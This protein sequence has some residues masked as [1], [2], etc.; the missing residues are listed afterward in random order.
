MPT[1]NIDYMQQEV[2]MEK[3]ESAH[4]TPPRKQNKTKT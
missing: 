3:S 4:P 2:K 1:A